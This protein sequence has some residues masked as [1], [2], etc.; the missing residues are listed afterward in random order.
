MAL[1]VCVPH[2]EGHYYFY[3]IMF[4]TRDMTGTD[5]LQ[6]YEQ[7]AQEVLAQVDAEIQALLEEAAR[8]SVVVDDSANEQLAQVRARLFGTDV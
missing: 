7:A 1:D 4:Y 5:T 3:T 8:R 2:V 6:T